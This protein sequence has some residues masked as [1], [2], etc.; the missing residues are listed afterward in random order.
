MH[1]GA[2]LGT[3]LPHAFIWI[4]VVAVIII[5]SVDGGAEIVFSPAP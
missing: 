1:E 2:H 4:G 3:R 5:D